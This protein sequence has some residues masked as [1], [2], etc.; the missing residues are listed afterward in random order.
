MGDMIAQDFFFRAQKRRAHGRDLRDDVDAIAI[1]LDHPPKPADL[2]LDAFE[3]LACRRLD[4]LAHGLYIPRGGICFKG[5]GRAAVTWAHTTRARTTV[6][7][8]AAA[9]SRPVRAPSLRALS[10]PVRCTRRSGRPVP[11]IV[12]S[13]ACRSNRSCLPPR[14]RTP[15]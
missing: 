7:P 11:A 4:I 14:L 10:I 15:S 8:G 2:A 9:S 3:P 13:A 6:P 12:R 5:C 1:V